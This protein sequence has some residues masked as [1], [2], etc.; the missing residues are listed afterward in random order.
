[1]NLTPVLS[2]SSLGVVVCAVVLATAGP[3]RAQTSDAGFADAL[4]TSMAS[5]VKSMHA[6]IRRNI[7]EAAEKMP[8]SDYGFKPTPQI[9]SFGELIGHVVNTNRLFCGQAAGKPFS[10]TTNYERVADKAALV[11]ALN[12]AL[13][14]CDAVVA[15]TTDANVGQVIKIGTPRGGGGEATR[16]SMLI[17]NTTH[18][19][20][21]YGNLVVY[22]RL[23]GIVPPSTARV[24]K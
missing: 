8:A 1:M 15:D 18:N 13:A 14:G 23:K 10:L 3:A 7:A 5:V 24:A 20:E 12:E 11:V 4:S 6:S 16:G 19:N 21:H 17:F 9:R 22:L 2:Q